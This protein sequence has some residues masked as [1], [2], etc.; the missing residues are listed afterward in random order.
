MDRRQ[1]VYTEPYQRP[2][3]ASPPPM[4]R[5]ESR[6]TFEGQ[7]NGLR[8]FLFVLLSAIIGGIAHLWV[9]L[10][11]LST[12]LVS[13][14]F[15]WFMW[16]A[17]LVFA[18]GYIHKRSEQKTEQMR[19]RAAMMDAATINEAQDEVLQMLWAECK[20]LHLRIDTLETLKIHEQGKARTIHKADPLDLRIKSWITSEIFN[21]NGRLVGVH[22]NGQLKK[23]MPFKQDK[24][25]A[26]DTEDGRGYTRLVSLGLIGRRDDNY[27]WVGPQTLPDAMARFNRIN[28]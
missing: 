12:L 19:I 6:P 15:L 26:Q 18:T 25:G 21:G 28:P 10:D 1:Y 2:G 9:G 24:P 5:M 23:A 7:S 20:S 17:D 27:V 22:P 13:M 14:I 3:A 4:Q 8:L 16:M 11:R